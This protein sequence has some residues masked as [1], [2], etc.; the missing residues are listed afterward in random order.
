MPLFGI[1]ISFIKSGNVSIM[2]LQDDFRNLIFTL[3]SKSDNVS[4][5]PL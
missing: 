1:D 3:Y 5:S 2:S 4:R